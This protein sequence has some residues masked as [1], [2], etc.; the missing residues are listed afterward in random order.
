MFRKVN[1]LV[2]TEN[3]DLKPTRAN[4][5][6][7]LEFLSRASQYDTAVLFIAGH[8]VRDNLRNFYF[9]PSDARLDKEGDIKKSSAIQYSQITE[10]L[11]G[12]RKLAFVDTC[13]SEGISGKKTRSIE[14]DELI[15]TNFQ[16]TGS[17]IFASSRGNEKIH[18]R[19][20][21]GPWCLH[22]CYP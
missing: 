12:A 8:A 16:D 1:S 7:N 2:L 13:H 9:L 5:T 20:R 21:V 14:V 15:K 3:S 17:Y 18:G 11:V 22:L 4:I 6:D 10:V 19:G